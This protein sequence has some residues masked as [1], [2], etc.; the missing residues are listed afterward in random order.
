MRKALWMI[1]VVFL[2]TG[3]GSTAAHADTLLCGGSTCSSG[4]YVTEIESLPIDG[5]LYNVT[6]GTTDSNP[7]PF[8]TN[9]DAGDA[10]SAIGSALGTSPIVSNQ[11]YFSDDVQYFC[12]DQG[13]STCI[14]LL[15][16]FYEGTSISGAWLAAG[17]NSNE[18]TAMWAAETGGIYFAQF[19]PAVSTPE[20]GS[21]PL[22]L[23][24]VVLLGLMVV[25][26]KR[27]ANRHPQ[28]T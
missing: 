22:T 3:L 25:M 18:L 15:N 12:V 6:F 11:T 26:R 21:A 14:L 13:G 9:G 5:T 17:N 7:A 4:G 19:L 1:P 27:V 2:F 16:V 24:G 8:N 23:T 28:A 10:A 20:P